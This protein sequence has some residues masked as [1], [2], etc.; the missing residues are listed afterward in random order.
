MSFRVGTG[1]DIHRLKKGRPLWLGGVH[2]AFEKGLDG[3]SDADALMHA[4]TDA[5]LGAAALPDIG[6]YFPPSDPSIKGIASSSMLAKAVQ[7][8]HRM[9]Y[10]VVNVDSVLVAEAPKI[11]PFRE[12]MRKIIARVLQ[13]PVSSVQIKGKTNEGLGEVGK[14]EAIAAHAIVLLQRISE[15]EY[16]KGSSL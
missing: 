6:H 7:E 10:R 11:A 4:I 14:G 9:G 2:I 3:H 15:I 16:R 12:A 1:Y 8:V 5:L 13:V